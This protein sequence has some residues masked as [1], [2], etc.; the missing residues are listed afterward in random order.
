[1]PGEWTR[2]KNMKP[3]WLV[4]WNWVLLRLLRDVRMASWAKLRFPCFPPLWRYFILGPCCGRAREHCRMQ[5]SLPRR[6]FP[7]IGAAR[8]VA[9]PSC[10]QEQR[11]TTE[12]CPSA[13][14]PLSSP[15]EQLV[16]KTS[17]NMIYHNKQRG[18]CFNW[19]IMFFS[20]YNFSSISVLHWLLLSSSPQPPISLLALLISTGTPFFI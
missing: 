6:S 5:C 11:Q 15:I 14:S 12:T 8:C 20:V 7:A 9:L 3:V 19:F 13:V 4:W 16:P 18:S 10:I 2:R 17:V 1:M